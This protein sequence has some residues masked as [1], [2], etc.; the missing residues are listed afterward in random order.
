MPSTRILL[1]PM[2]CAAARTRNS[3]IKASSSASL[4]KEPKSLICTWLRSM[5]TATSGFSHKGRRTFS[6]MSPLHSMK[7]RNVKSNQFG[8]LSPSNKFSN[9]LFQSSRKRSLCQ[10]SR[11]GRTTTTKP[12]KSTFRRR[13]DE[14]NSTESSRTI[15]LPAARWTLSP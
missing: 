2:S 13:A 5:E 6:Q 10:H 7:C 8:T 12:R 4:Q 9:K 11:S 15:H 14:A 1:R 3:M